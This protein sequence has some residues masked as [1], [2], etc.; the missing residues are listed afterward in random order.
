MAGINKIDTYGLGEIVLKLTAEGKRTYEIPDELNRIL[1]ER[2]IRNHRGEYETISQPTVSRWLKRYRQD[3]GEQTRAMVNERIKPIVDEILGN[4][5]RV[6]LNMI[7]IHENR[8]GADKQISFLG[9]TLKTRMDAGMKAVIAGEKI[10]KLVGI[11]ADRGDDDATQALSADEIE[12]LRKKAREVIEG[13]FSGK[14][15]DE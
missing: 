1:R 3:L 6:H 9:N 8:K 4:M 5:Y 13:G 10:L 11:E 14:S 15:D 12:L 2:G 7:A